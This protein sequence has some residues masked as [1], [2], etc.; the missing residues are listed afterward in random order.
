VYL[1]NRSSRAGG[2]GGDGM[3]YLRPAFLHFLRQI[4]MSLRKMLEFPREISKLFV[5]LQPKR[6]N[7]RIMSYEERKAKMAE[8]R[9]V[10]SKKP[11]R[12][13]FMRWARA[14]KG[15]FVINDPEL[16]SQLAFS[17]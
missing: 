11:A 5:N 9:A 3:A 16:K 4:A 14:H 17:E 7:I 10:N 12:S 8:N 6:F 1:S 2:L 15:A 13:A